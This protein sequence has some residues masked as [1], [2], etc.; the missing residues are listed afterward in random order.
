MTREIS[1]DSSEM[2]EHPNDQGN[3]Y[4]P[5]RTLRIA[6]WRGQSRAEKNVITVAGGAVA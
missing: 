2:H 5:Y 6:Q 4:A 1:F 3:E